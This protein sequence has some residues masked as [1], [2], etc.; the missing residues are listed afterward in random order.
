MIARLTLFPAGLILFLG[1]A[2]CSDGGEI[3]R[4]TSTDGKKGTSYEISF[5]GGKSI[6]RLTAFCPKQKK[7][8]YLSWDRDQKAPTPAS[9]IWDHRT[10]EIIQLYKFTDCIDLLPIIPNVNAMKVCP[11]TGDTKFK[12]KRTGFYD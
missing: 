12:V 3:Y 8:V 4:I 10:G 7:F 5:G 2:L 11:F 1:V 6:E 9:T